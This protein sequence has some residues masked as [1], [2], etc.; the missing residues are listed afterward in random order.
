MDL[1]ERFHLYTDNHLGEIGKIGVTYQIE[2]TTHK[3]G[4]KQAPY[5]RWSVVKQRMRDS[6]DDASPTALP[7][8][9]EQRVA[10]ILC[11]TQ[12]LKFAY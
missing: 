7:M 2:I 5:E 11:H 4:Q 3:K 9:T 10:V 8:T 1:V 6:A 12:Y